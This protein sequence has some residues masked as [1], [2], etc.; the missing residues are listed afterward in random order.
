MLETIV[1]VWGTDKIGAGGDRMKER[2]VDSQDYKN[3]GGRSCYD[4]NA[5]GN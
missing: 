4:P 5:D 1:E 3:S 2:K